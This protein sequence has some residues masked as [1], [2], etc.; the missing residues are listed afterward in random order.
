VLPNNIASR[1]PRMVS[2]NGIHSAMAY[3]FVIEHYAQLAEVSGE[4][5]GASAWLLPGAA[6]GFNTEAQAK[7]LLL[8]QQQKA[9]DKGA[10][11]AAQVAAQIRLRAV[12]RARENLP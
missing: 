1:L 10:M 12:F 5:F 8:D 2:E 4:M 7:Q 3:Q 6:S 9:G 11:T